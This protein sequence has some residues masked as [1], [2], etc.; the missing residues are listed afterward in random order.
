MKKM[1]LLCLSL[2]LPLMADYFR[3]GMMAYKAGQFAQAKE[4][5]ELAIKKENS[6]QGYY[7]LGK[8]FLLGE[9]VEANATLAIPYL[10][11]AVMKGNLKAKCYLAEAYL[12]TRIKVDEAITLL[13]EESSQQY[14][15]C[16]EIATK[17]NT[18]NKGPRP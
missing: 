14:P 5:F 15:I 4:N 1:I 12:K 9:G 17:Y 8:M 7:Y 6:V 13:N 2:S 16:Q 11:Q 18:V 3:D 10:E